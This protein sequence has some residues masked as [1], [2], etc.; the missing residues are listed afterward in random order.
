MEGIPEADIK[1]HEQQKQA[2]KKFQTAEGAESSD[3][4]GG[5]EAKKLKASQPAV[6]DQAASSTPTMGAIP[7]NP[8]MGGPFMGMGAMTHYMGHVPIMGA[9]PQMPLPSG[10]IPTPPTSSKPLF[11]SAGSSTTATVTS[12][13]PAF[14]AYGSTGSGATIVGESTVPKKSAVIAT[15]AGSTKIMHPEEDLSLEELRARHPRYQK[16][17][18]ISSSPQVVMT[19]QPTSLPPTTG[20]GGFGI[21]M[22]GPIPAGMMIPMHM[23]PMALPPHMQMGMAPM[24][25]IRAPHMPGMPG[26]ISPYGTPLG[27]P[28]MPPRFR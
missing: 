28:M 7:M 26:G 14:A 11:P 23:P 4:E 22:G 5:P 24:G 17:S 10:S 2:G 21:P 1:E 9:M 25:L 6:Q 13:K 8:V 15:Q 3:E 12:S 27:F 18:V 19:T 16:A 20:P